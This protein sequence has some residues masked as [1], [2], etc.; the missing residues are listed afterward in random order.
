MLLLNSA[1]RNKFGK[2]LNLVIDSANK[3]NVK[4]TILSTVSMCKN[5]ST[6]RR[7]ARLCPTVVV[8]AVSKKL[9]L[10]CGSVAASK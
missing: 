4:F 8:R 7:H 2:Q 5:N 1:G 6:H 10:D 9:R 3:F